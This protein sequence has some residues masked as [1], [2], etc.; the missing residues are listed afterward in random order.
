MSVGRFLEESERWSR[1]ATQQMPAEVGSMLRRQLDIDKNL[2]TS[3]LAF[4]NS[5]AVKDAAW[6]WYRMALAH[7]GDL[8]TIKAVTSSYLR[9]QSSSY[10]DC[11]SLG[12]TAAFLSKAADAADECA[13]WDELADVLYAV[14][15]HM[16]RT[17]Y[18]IDANIPWAKLSPIQAEM[19]RESLA[20]GS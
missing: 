13:G 20:E 1:L 6:G 19:V 17:Y 12:E 14:V 2:A 4:G 15:H 3:V 7:E 18:W 10:L 5:Y 8:D 11:Y 9:G 16:V